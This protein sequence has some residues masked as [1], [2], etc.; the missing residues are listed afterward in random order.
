[1]DIKKI[2]DNGKQAF[3]RNYWQCVLVALIMGLLTA[4]T[5]VSSA[6]SAQ[7]TGS[8]S[9]QE[10]TNAIKTLTP[11]E[12][13]A[14]AGAVMAAIWLKIIVG[15]VMRIFVF[16]PIEVGGYRFFKKNNLESTVRAG[17]IKEG[18]GNYGHTFA[19]LFLRDLFLAF[20][21][22]LLFIPGIVK[23]YSYRLVPYLVK[24]EPELSAIGVIS[25]SRELMNG[26][27]LEAFLMDISFIGWF[28]LGV[29]TLGIVDVF[30]T[31][32]YYESAKANFYLE[33][34]N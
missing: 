33:L 12:Q 16:N 9:Q 22:I 10:L 23:S 26:H 13:M 2:K 28:L 19:T 7:S 27:K 32:P 11:E 17:A 24:D 1:M 4:G 14:I 34:T 8:A 30:W 25:R 15:L 21:F 29:L 5:A 18:F 6:N 31:D 3:K 20:W